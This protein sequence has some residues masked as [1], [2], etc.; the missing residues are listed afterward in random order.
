MISE[1]CAY[2]GK[3][4]NPIFEIHLVIKESAEYMHFQSELSKAQKSTNTSLSSTKKQGASKHSLQTRSSLASATLS[5]I[6]IGGVHLSVIKGDITKTS[7]DVI[8]NTTS[9]DINLGNSG[10]VSKILLQ[11][12]GSELQ[13]LCKTAVQNEGKLTEGKVIATKALKP[14]NCASIFHIY[15]SSNDPKMYFETIK[16]CLVKA[17]Q[18]QYK[19]IALPAIGTGA[20]NYPTSDAAKGTMNAVQEFASINP[21]HVQEIQIVIFHQ[22]VYDD[23]VQSL[24]LQEKDQPDSDATETDQSSDVSE[25][26]EIL[27]LTDSD[28]NC[29]AS[30]SDSSQE[31]DHRSVEKEEDKGIQAFFRS[32]FSM[33]SSFWSSNESKGIRG[34]DDTLQSGTTDTMITRGLKLN[35][36]GLVQSQVEDAVKRLHEIMREN[37]DKD[38]IQMDSIK[39]LLENECAEI[40]SACKEL[41]VECFIETDIG[42]IQLTGNVHDISK[43]KDKVH[44]IIYEVINRNS[45]QHKEELRKQF[46]E[47]GC[48]KAVRW[49]CM[50]PN[51]SNDEYD[52]Y[53]K[54]LNYAIEQAYQA[55]LKSGKK[56]NKFRYQNNPYN[57]TVDFKKNEEKDHKT[58]QSREIR[59]IDVVKDA[60]R[61]GE[62][63]D[64]IMTCG[65]SI[66]IV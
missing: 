29:S 4:S 35:I 48:Y 18:L 60:V 52:D 10:Q 6:F 46:E 13:D 61:A 12:A 59:R 1:S 63:S 25:P 54:T 49:Q 58:K 21:Q 3:T 11:I 38:E 2:L 62:S 26:G 55:Y 16:A 31:D 28:D 51:S 30:N 15:F 33:I 41:G 65:N 43:I 56:N 22:S 39:N 34:I 8:V 36:F 47:D 9:S 50:K 64:M 45:A 66:L 17:E 57:F 19:S 40:I 44:G 37:L 5:E 42:R 20:Q 14:L 53:D 24:T 7:S 23:F 27:L 32:G